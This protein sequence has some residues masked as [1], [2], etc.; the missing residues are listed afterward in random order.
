MPVEKH[1]YHP[2]AAC[3]MYRSCGDSGVVKRGLDEVGAWGRCCEH[4]W[5]AGRAVTDSDLAT[6]IR[7]V[8]RLR[9]WADGEPCQVEH[10]RNA[11]DKLEQ[12]A[13]EVKR[14][15]LGFERYEA[16]RK[17]NA[18]E[19]AELYRRNIASGI[20][21]DDLVDALRSKGSVAR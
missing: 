14:L 21:F 20:A 5:W 6:S 11:A 15:Q 9:G 8:T 10:I 19:F 13:A 1:E 18:N 4:V 17:L 16:V 2:Y 12:S 3:L 7:L